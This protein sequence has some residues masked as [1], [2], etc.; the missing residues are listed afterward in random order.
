MIVDFEDIEALTDNALKRFEA[1]VAKADPAD[2]DEVALEITR[3]ESKLEQ[4]YSFTAIMARR[5][6]DVVRT[7][8]LWR[9][10]VQICDLFAGR[11]YQLAQRYPI[12]ASTYDN[13]LDIRGAAE[14]L[15]VLHSAP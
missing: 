12:A 10:L 2:P 8:D 4:L 3:L 9:N 7:A 13:M 14:E 15:R 6:A 5:E 1:A 11:V